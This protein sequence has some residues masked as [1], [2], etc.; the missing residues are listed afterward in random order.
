MNSYEL[1]KLPMR[2]EHLA[3]MEAALLST[4]QRFRAVTLLSDAPDSARA[5]RRMAIDVLRDWALPVSADDVALC[6]SELVGN[7]IHHA[8]PD[9]WLARPGGAR[10]IAVAF[11]AWPK[12]LF[13][14]VGDED[15]TPPS[16]PAGEFHDPELSEGLPEA[17]L[18]DSGRG[19]AIVQSLADTVWWAPREPGGKSVF[20]RFG[21]DTR[22]GTSRCDRAPEAS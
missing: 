22:E 5:A 4:A 14:E 18:P 1:Q 7:S 12:W 11:R 19:L 10:R 3:P 15:S 16:L 2:S 20:C 9:I 21:L 8:V 6:V 13:V 17:L